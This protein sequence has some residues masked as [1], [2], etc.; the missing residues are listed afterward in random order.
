MSADRAPLKVIVSAYACEP[1]LGS[2]P[3]VGWNIAKQIARF[4]NVWVITRSN[5]R[6]PIEETLQTNP[7]PNLRFVYFDLP[8]WMRFWKR[9]QRG[10][11]L[12]YYIWQVGAY[13]VAKRLHSEIAFD[14]AHHVTFVKYWAPSFLALLPI[15]FIWGPVGGGESSP[16][17]F[18]TEF[19]LRGVMLETVRDAARRVFELDPFVRLTAQRATI[20]LATTP[21]TA[22][23][24]KQL[25]QGSV[26]VLSQVGL[27]ADEIAQLSRIPFRSTPPFRLISVGNI[28]HWKGFSLSL[29]AFAHLHASLPASEYW[30]IG[31]GPEGKHLET[32]AR[33]LGVTENVI[34][35][36]RLPRAEVFRK[37]A[38]CD[39]L[40][41]PS[42]H[43]SGGWVCAEAMA[44]GRPVVCLDLGGPALL[45]TH[46]TGF[47]IPAISPRQAVA[48][49]LQATLCLAEDPELR[50]RMGEA[51][52]QRVQDHFSW[53]HKG[54]YLSELYDSVVEG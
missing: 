29:K 31:A 40:V 1:N 53:Q 34:F 14:L 10:V 13:F 54:D 5:N 18:L 49:L 3:G 19:S 17:S 22:T 28:L 42:L 39:V 46:R 12:Y 2:E 32:L 23:R 4:H 47:K 27:P 43:D 37:L 38:M 33:E 7:V 35:W 41:H 24:L 50:M 15:P 20:A 16:R 9:G 44:A 52:K 8:F 45:V 48:D 21:E 30:L 51:A 6:K 25:A 26:K 11:Q 36:G